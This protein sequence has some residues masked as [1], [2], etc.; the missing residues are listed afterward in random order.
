MQHPGLKILTLDIETAPATVRTFGLFNQNLGLN[1]IVDPGGPICFGAKWLDKKRVQFYSE[2]DGGKEGLAAAAWK[3]MNEADCII[4]YNGVS[5]DEKHLKGLMVAHGLTPPSKHKPVDL[6]KIVK[7]NFRFLSNK[8]QHV[9]EQLEVG[10]KMKHEGFDLWN[11]WLD[12]DT[13]AQARMKKYC[14]Q[15]VKLTEELFHLLDDLGWIPATAVPPKSLVQGVHGKAGEMCPH[16]LGTEIVRNGWN[17]TS[18][19]RYATYR[20]KDCGKSHSERTA[21]FMMGSKVHE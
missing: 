21:E 13:A 15:D 5:F 18:V 2:L 16:C 7:K 6:L 17:M 20:C 14:I 9:A 8:L 3:L 11:G 12:G 19:G 10:S 4:H 1:Q